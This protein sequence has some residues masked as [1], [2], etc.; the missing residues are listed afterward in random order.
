MPRYALALALVLTL[1]VAPLLGQLNAWQDLKALAGRI[2]TSAGA[3]PLIALGADETTV[4]MLSL[5]IPP[6][7]RGAVLTSNSEQ[8]LAAAR[9][10]LAASRGEARIL[11]LVPGGVRWGRSDWL[12]FLG[13]GDQ[14]AWPRPTVVPPAGLGPVRLECVVGRPGGRSF[15]LLASADAAPSGAACR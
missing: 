2:T 4:A 1:V 10:A 3:R 5:Y 15:A 6:R 12:A 13:Y 8:A 11:W 7:E 14:R 9:R